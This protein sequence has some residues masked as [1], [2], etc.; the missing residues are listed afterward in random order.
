MSANASPHQYADPAALR[1]ACRE[2]RFTGA[3]T[4]QCPGFAQANVVILPHA[5][6]WDFLLFCQRNPKA[7]P[8]LEVFEAGDP[9]SGTFAP[10]ADIRTDC[11]AY[12][13]VANGLAT[14][15]R[16]V[17]E[18]W[19]EDAVTFLLGCSFTFEQALM[20]AR[21]P[22]RHVE[23][24]RNVA[25]F[26]TNRP[27]APAGVFQ[28]PMVVSMRPVQAA[29]VAEAV[30]VT[31]RF[32]AVHGAPVHVGAPESLGIRSLAQPDWGDA[33]DIRPDEVPV[34]WACG[35]SGLAALET[36]APPFA[37]THAP[38]C[39]LVGDARDAAFAI[40]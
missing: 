6:A 25:M 26:R 29:R 37:I 33:V 12:L 15:A 23:Q 35:V 21:V 32:P 2:G 8:L 22:M 36:V 20:E 4:G 7:L 24:G 19:R 31:A 38:G 5:L 3:T 17:R 13:T 40:G 1:R 18:C 28:G 14:P 10:G 9:V 16:D 11:P 27:L 39:M 30:L 34:F